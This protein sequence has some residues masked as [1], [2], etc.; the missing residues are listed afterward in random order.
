MGTFSIWHWLIVLLV[1]LIPVVLVGYA[2][3][4]LPRLGFTLRFVGAALVSVV[5]GAFAEDVPA[6]AIVAIVPGLLMY[7][8]TALR[9]ND[10]GWNRWLALLWF[11]W[12]VGLI[13]S[14]AL[15]FKRTAT[16]DVAPVFD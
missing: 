5:A 11:L 6:A 16:K 3:A 8:W 12:P 15:C 2:R 13:L 9:L 14:L 4:K 7:R 10:V 1:L